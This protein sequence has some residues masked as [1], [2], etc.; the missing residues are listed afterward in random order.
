MVMPANTLRGYIEP[1]IG[2]NGPPHLSTIRIGTKS[3]AWWPYRY[4]SDPDSE[5][6]LR[7]FEEVVAS[8]RQ[9]AIQAHFSHPKE[10]QHPA[11][12]E[13]IRLIRMTGAQIRS[14][15]PLIKHVNDSPDVWRDMWNLQARMGLIPYYMFVER[16]TGAADYFATPLT[17]AFEIFSTAY[18]QLSGTARTV[19]GP[20]MS[21]APGKVC[22]VGEDTI[23]GEKVFVLKFLQARNPKWCKQVFFAKHD[24]KAVWFDSLKP[25]FG[26]EKF[27]FE[28]DYRDISTRTHQGSSGQ[29]E[30]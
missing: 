12:Q 29:L 21:A 19:R 2:P 18:S 20:S 9:L 25:A 13:A 27:F 23:M 22:V 15:G 7:L 8:G 3:L 5:D 17:K 10:L 28:D 6:V 11:A 4:I 30:Y 24:P 26:Q 14:Q 16:D 1:L